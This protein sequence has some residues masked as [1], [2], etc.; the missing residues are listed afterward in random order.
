MREDF[1]SI[2]HFYAVNPERRR[3]LEV[4]FGVMW[5]DGGLNW[6]NYRVSWVE[7]TGEFYAVRLAGSR[8]ASPVEL[9]GV[10]EDR[11]AAEVA[12]SGWA[13]LD[14]MRLAWA[15]LR[16]AGS[17]DDGQETMLLERIVRV[18]GY[19][20][21]VTDDDWLDLLEGDLTLSMNA[22]AEKYGVKVTADVVTVDVVTRAAEEV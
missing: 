1:R 21:A 20:P 19:P 15:R 17:R 18:H 14:A 4:D 3:S 22:V 13:E 11:E 12:L 8:G 6:P 16:L 5:T 9:L 10:A 2:E 7:S